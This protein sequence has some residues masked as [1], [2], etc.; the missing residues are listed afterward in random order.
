MS[1]FECQRCGIAFK[2]KQILI[3]HL[4][5]KNICIAIY[6]DIQPE[7]LIELLQAKDGIQCDECSKTY[8]NNECLRIHKIRAHKEN[9]KAIV[10][11][12]EDS[13]TYLKNEINDLK[14]IILEMA[15]NPQTV[16]NI[17]NINNTM[18]ITLNCLMDTTGKPIEYL[19]N[20]DNITD[21]ILDWMK[22]NQ[23]LIPTY[24][25]E[26][27]YNTEHPENHMIRAGK[28]GDSIELY[29]S[30]KWK[31]YENVKG[32]DLILTNIGN[33]FGLFLEIIKDNPHLYTEKKK[34]LTQFEKDI[35]KPLNWGLEVSDDSNGDNTFQLI[36]NEKG[37]YT[38]YEEEENRIKNIKLQDIAIKEVHTK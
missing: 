22:L 18:N 17:N 16:N 13:Y 28:D 8:K 30:G 32:A 38:S 4:Y 29:I 7:Q 36:K 27:Y 19:L 14:N 10:E 3:K 26:K 21:L 23:K 11:K 20:Q 5:R 34:I 35:I 15:K 1:S 24:M 37:Q 31:K 6:N 12:K 25:K 33:D 9:I 2:T